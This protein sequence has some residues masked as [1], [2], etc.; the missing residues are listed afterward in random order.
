MIVGA[1]VDA[2]G[3]EV[4]PAD[5]SVFIDHEERALGYAFGLR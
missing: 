1:G 3:R 5:D 4:A 2:D